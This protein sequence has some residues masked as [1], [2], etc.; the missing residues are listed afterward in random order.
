MIRAGA[1]DELIKILSPTVVIDDVGDEEETW[2]VLF[3]AWAKRVDVGAR[4]VL[5]NPQISGTISAIFTIRHPG[6]SFDARCR[7]E[8]DAGRLY[9][10][11]APPTELPGRRRGFE[12][13]AQGLDK[14]G[15]TV[16]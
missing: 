8:D 1:H 9:E 2:P 3:K 15:A 16:A 5:R 6:V 10:I 7:I 11:V 13:Q 14:L 12:I 4:E